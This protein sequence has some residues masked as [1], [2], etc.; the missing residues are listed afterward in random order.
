MPALN[1]DERGFTFIEMMLVLLVITILLAIT[2]P[3]LAKQSASIKEKGCEA[4]LQVVEAQV[5]AYEMDTGAF[6][7]TLTQLQEAGYI[8]AE[9]SCGDTGQV[10]IQG[11]GSVEYQPT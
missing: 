2:I 9:G 6:P 8:Q 5:Q 10:V 7:T 4:F 1:R 3:N 11:D